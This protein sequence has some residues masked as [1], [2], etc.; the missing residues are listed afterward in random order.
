MKSWPLIIGLAACGVL[1]GCQDAGGDEPAGQ[2][3]LQ[4]ATRNAH[5]GAVTAGNLIT[6][7]I[8]DT[9]HLDVVFYPSDFLVPGQVGLVEP[10]MSQE[11]QERFVLALYDFSGLKDSFLVGSMSG[12]DIKDFLLR[13]TIDARRI[14]LQVAG[15]RYSAKVRGGFPEQFEAVLGAGRP[16]EDDVRYRVA[17]SEY[18]FG[19]PSA[20]PGYKYHNNLQRTFRRQR[21]T[22][23]ARA[24]L[25]SY[26]KDRDFFPD[27]KAPRAQLTI[28]KDVHTAAVSIAQIQ[29]PGHLSPLLGHEV[30]TEGVIT[31][32][33]KGWLATGNGGPSVRGFFLQ[34]PADGDER[35]SDGIYVE[36][37]SDAG[38]IKVGNRVAIKGTV[39]E[40]YTTEGLTRTTLREVALTLLAANQDLPEP[41]V[42]GVGG[43][44]PPSKVVSSYQGNV[45]RRQAV[46]TSEG[47]GFWESLEGMRVVAKSPQ[48]VGVAGGKEDLYSRAPKSY[49]NIF[50]AVDGLTDKERLVINGESRTYH[51]GIILIPNGPF[52]PA[53]S[54]SAVFSV[55]DRFGYDLEGIFTYAL[56]NFGSGEYSLYVTGAFAGTQTDIIP[57]KERPQTPL[58][59]D[60][61]HLTIANFNV[62][63]LAGKEK[64]RIAQVAEVIGTSLNCP[65]IVNLVEIMD[66]NGIDFRG[67]PSGA[68]TLQAIIDN[69]ACAG[70]YKLV[71]IDPVNHRE[72]GKPGGNIR[73]AMIYN[74]YRVGFKSYGDA[75][76]L[77]ETIIYPDGT[78]SHNPGRV[79]PNDPVFNGTRRPLVAMFTFHG[80]QIYVIGN[81]FNSK[82]GDDSHY[83]AQQPPVFHSD[84]K[85][86]EIATLVNRFVERLKHF[87]PAA[88]VVVLGDFNEFYD[89]APLAILKGHALRNLVED[90]PS[91]ERYTYSFRGNSQSLDYVLVSN[92][93]YR[94]HAPDIDIVHINTDYMGMVS[95]HDPMVARLSFA[96][97]A[98]GPRPCQHR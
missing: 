49:L 78:L 84:T 27:L 91:E 5:L 40:D 14:D 33:G 85:R 25:L 12:A 56:N 61:D 73:V 80:K 60:E 34:G 1:S 10:A 92:D 18:A 53:V 39:Y 29:G 70:A 98:E 55:G 63:N 31:A 47:L 69:L 24:A 26:L 77:T 38:V 3:A 93:L 11:R 74:S 23:S 6:T 87:N 89:A 32:V 46:D 71:N 79:F 9:H 17:V 20:F 50:V 15:V 42:L 22:I 96:R 16:L 90:C 21:Q 66:E 35:T 82:G 7:A 75:K 41:V 51:P 64:D 97:D 94:N 45:N 76:S 2:P 28:S 62:E 43:R 95:D 57:L 48:V 67:E 37:T 54:N 36:A 81:H 59:G 8:R 65:D 88:G 72:G 4:L 83:G 86:S 58:A 68:P 44:L 30:T 52:S 13:R 19:P